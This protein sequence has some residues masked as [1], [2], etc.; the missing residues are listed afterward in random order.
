[1]N[2]A[3]ITPVIITYNE[4]PNIG[5]CLD[6]LTWANV[7]DLKK[8]SS[9]VGKLYAVKGIP[10]NFLLDKDGKIIAKNLRGKAL[11]DKLAEVLK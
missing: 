6:K 1:M 2:L 8:W 4:A 10:M 11:E 3:D 5:R 7:S 9:E